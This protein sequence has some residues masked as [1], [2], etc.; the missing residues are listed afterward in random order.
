M[1]KIE[2]FD[3]PADD[4]QRA[5]KFYE[6]LFDWRIEKMP[7][8]AEYY[9]IITEEG[10]LQGGVSQRQ[11]D[12]K[13][14]NFVGVDNIDKYMNSV[15]KHGGKVLTPKIEVSGYGWLATCKD[16]EGNS[17]GLWQNS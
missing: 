6:D 17:F 16:T 11:G 14:T 5:K 2:R 15:K 3:I 12:Q 4:I 7:G 1:P 10:A 8:E 9:S 13:I